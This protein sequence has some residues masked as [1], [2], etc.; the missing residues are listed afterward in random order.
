PISIAPGTSPT[1]TPLSKDAWPAKAELLKSHGVAARFMGVGVDRIDYTKGILER[2]RA[3]EQ[4]LA[5]NP[6]YVGDFTF[7]ELGA[8]SRT[9]IKRYDDLTW[10][11]PQEAGR[12]NTRFQTREWKPIVMLKGQHSHQAIEPYYR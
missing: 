10:E 6:S 11:I 2:F 12:I 8:P 1:G 9:G 5:N 3:V 7:V 4:F